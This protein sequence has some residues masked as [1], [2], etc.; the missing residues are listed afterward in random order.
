MNYSQTRMSNPPWCMVEQTFLSVS[1]FLLPFMRF[2][3][4]S[5]KHF[6]LKHIINVYN[7]RSGIKTK[8]LLI[9]IVKNYS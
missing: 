3:L 4:E 6:I 2:L 8:V 7:V 5:C 1:K 9:L